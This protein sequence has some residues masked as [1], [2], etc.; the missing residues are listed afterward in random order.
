[1]PREP[2]KILA[3]LAR[4]EKELEEL[5]QAVQPVG[6]GSADTSQVGQ[7]VSALLK[8]RMGN[9]ERI[10]VFNTLQKDPAQPS[11]WEEASMSSG[12]KGTMKIDIA[13]TSNLMMSCSNETRLV[14]AGHHQV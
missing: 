11:G 13:K 10:V 4:V 1:M 9:W 5:K 6:G 7:E 12:Y 14:G 2:A 3:R 8:K